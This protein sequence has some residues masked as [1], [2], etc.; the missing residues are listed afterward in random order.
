MTVVRDLKK[1]DCSL[2]VEKLWP[3]GF[4]NTAKY[5]H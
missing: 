2:F 4:M 3:P 1:L 5:L